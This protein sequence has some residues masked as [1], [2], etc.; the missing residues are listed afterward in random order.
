MY[1]EVVFNS[2]LPDPFSV[3]QFR[4]TTEDHLSKKQFASDDRCYMVRVLAT[5]LLS[6]ITR[7][8]MRDCEKPWFT[9]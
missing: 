4:E 3:L 1:M 7:P 5:M 2:K 6:H 9:R 8:S